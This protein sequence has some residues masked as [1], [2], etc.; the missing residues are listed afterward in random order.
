LSFDTLSFIYQIL[1]L[2]VVLSFLC[3]LSVISTKARIKNMF[4][5]IIVGKTEKL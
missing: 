4:D 5:E 2:G 1:F 3:A